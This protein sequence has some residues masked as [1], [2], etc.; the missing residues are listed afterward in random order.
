MFDVP[1]AP[2]G[3]MPNILDMS[4]AGGAAPNQMVLAPGAFANGVGGLRKK[5]VLAALVCVGV[6]GALGFWV[7]KTFTAHAKG[8]K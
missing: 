5:G 1:P 8:R 4:S 7:A 3:S 6:G 2:T